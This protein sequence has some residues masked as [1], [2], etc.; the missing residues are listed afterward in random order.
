M[1]ELDKDQPVPE[2]L[3]TIR[4]PQNLKQLESALPKP[5]YE[6]LLLTHVDKKNFLLELEK[7]LITRSVKSLGQASKPSGYAR[8]KSRGGQDREIEHKNLD[9]NKSELPAVS[10]TENSGSVNQSDLGV[11]NRSSLPVV[12]RSLNP[13]SIEM[14]LR[15]L[16]KQAD[17]SSALGTN[18]SSHLL[19]E[20]HRKNQSLEKQ[21]NSHLRRLYDQQQYGVGNYAYKGM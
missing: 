15:Y 19:Q 11:A 20:Y 3:K 10:L 12:K 14:K 2:L 16:S 6:P 8:R 17:Y 7:N 1:T 4:V 21:A 9:L 13:P 18:N 5:N